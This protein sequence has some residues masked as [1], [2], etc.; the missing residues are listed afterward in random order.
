MAIRTNNILET[1]NGVDQIIQRNNDFVSYYDS[2]PNGFVNNRFIN[3]VT[4]GIDTININNVKSL[5]DIYPNKRN[6][7]TSFMDIH[8]N[9][10]CTRKKTNESYIT[11]HVE[12]LSIDY[13]Y[14]DIIK[15]SISTSKFFYIDGNS[16]NINIKKYNDSS[17]NFINIASNVEP[18][19]KLRDT[20]LLLS[21]GIYQSEISKELLYNFTIDANKNMLIYELK[22][23]NVSYDTASYLVYVMVANKAISSNSTLSI[24]DGSS[25]ITSNLS[26]KIISASIS[27]ANYS[28][29]HLDNGTITSNLS[30]GTPTVNSIAKGSHFYI[31][32]GNSGNHKF[33]RIE[34]NY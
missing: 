30:T 29:I 12:N 4:T 28:N 15:N 13:K 21:N 1:L 34:V 10:Y 18:L 5:F 6:T 2:I 31:V 25:D 14:S 9:G 7:T 20:S 26:Y 19:V 11:D 8:T 17:I 22:I 27:D 3:P 32:I 16:I 24:Y 23:G 33:N